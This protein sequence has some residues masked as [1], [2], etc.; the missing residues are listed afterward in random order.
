MG[1]NHLQCGDKVS[2]FSAILNFYFRH[3]VYKNKVFNK[4][5]ASKVVVV[6]YKNDFGYDCLSSFNI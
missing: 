4:Y 6:M 1:T 2:K 5:I 3:R